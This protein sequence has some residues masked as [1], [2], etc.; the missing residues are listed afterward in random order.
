[1]GIFGAMTTAVSGLKAQSYAMENI[2]GNIA[3]ARTTGFKRVDTSFVD[4]VPDR[5]AN[6]EQAGSVRAFSQ[7][8]NTSQGDL[9]TTGVAENIALNSD[10][11]FVVRERTGYAG[12]VPT[13]G[14]IDVY[15]RRGDFQRD[16][17]G[18]LVN[19]AGFY[20]KGIPL[21]PQTGALQGSNPQLIR[22]SEAN[23]PPK[24]T[25]SVEY[26]ATLPQVPETNYSRS[27]TAATPAA[28]AA[29]TLLGAGGAPYGAN[30]ATIAPANSQ[31]FIDR[32][33]QGGSVTIYND[34]G[35]AKPL[36]L[37]WGKVQNAS[38]APAA[39]E[40]WSLYYQESSDPLA[41]NAWVRAN[42][43]PF[44]FNSAGQ[45]APPQNVTLPAGFTLDGIPYP[46][47]ITLNTS[48]VQSFPAEDIS[49]NRTLADISK[50]QQ[51]G[52]ASGQFQTIGIDSSGRV[53]GNYT[54]GQ[55]VGL[56]QI[57]VAQF[58]ADNSLKR[59]DGGVFEQTLESGPPIIEQ[60][61]A[62][63]V[64]G[65]VENSNTDIADEFSKM[66]VTQQ[67]YSAN[68]RIIST[69]SDMLRDVIN[70]IR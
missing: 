1:M 38:I 48:T 40:Q 68:T 52:Y 23:V 53:I 22:I 64:G 69:S 47:A 20:L 46:T 43:T 60:A 3:N 13:F 49:A 50:I 24:P 37:R 8:T 31:A 15:T 45:Q 33:I 12:G 42:A 44:T 7:A 70:I 51:D 61:G 25:A 67:A 62:N 28:A 17:S 65:T 57:V 55:V 10:G 27:T 54:N 30:P 39:A 29:N 26:G 19:G 36:N 63:V 5:P 4:L 58:A 18:Y 56:A 9:N 34:Q 66:I 21:D 35:A 32:S 16:N 11:F 14:G 2:S 41:P 59:R 6:Q